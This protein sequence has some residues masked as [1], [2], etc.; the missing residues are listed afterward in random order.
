M[1]KHDDKV[2]HHLFYHHQVNISL[3]AAP[4]EALV[5]ENLP[6]RAGGIRDVG[7][8]P[9][10]GRCPGRGNSNSLQYSFLENPMDR[11]AWR[12]TVHGA[13]KSWAQLKQLST[14]STV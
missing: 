1:R 5:V 4:Q 7:F 12:P 6:A 8:I 11:G 14:C 2:K 3:E 13:A 9:G 10:S